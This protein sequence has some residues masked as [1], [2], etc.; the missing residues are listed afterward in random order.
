MGLSL[1]IEYRPGRLNLADAPCRRPDYKDHARGLGGAT[2]IKQDTTIDI[3]SLTFLA[4]PDDRDV[5]LEGVLCEKQKI[6][7]WIFL[8]A[9]NENDQRDIIAHTTLQLAASDELAYEEISL[10]MQTVIQAL[11]KV[12]PLA[13]HW[14]AAIIKSN[15]ISTSLSDS[16]KAHLGVSNL[17]QPNVVDDSDSP[18]KAHLG[19]C[20]LKQPNVVDDSHSLLSSLSSSEDLPDSEESEWQL[21]DGLLVF[22]DILY[23][24]PGVLRREAVRFNHDN[25]LAGHFGY[26]RTLELVRRK[27]HWPSISRDI[28]EYVN[29][30]DTCHQI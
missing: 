22:K 27:Y 18:T 11:Q 8:L 13:I 16:T 7:P 15:K 9:G 28:K 26:L 3:A 29:T 23:V 30:C 17:K 21:K 20:N 1:A 2:W 4:L 14:R 5:T 10:T 6:R 25:P 19:V 12:D 24:L